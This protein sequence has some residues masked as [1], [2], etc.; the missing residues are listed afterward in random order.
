MQTLQFDSYSKEY[1]PIVSLNGSTSFIFLSSAGEERPCSVAGDILANI[2]VNTAA[3]GTW[4]N[5]IHIY[6]FV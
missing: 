4:L 1:V 2:I 6:I 5:S 3:V